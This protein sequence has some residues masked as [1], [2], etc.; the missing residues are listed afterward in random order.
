MALRFT[1]Q[2]AY[3]EEV[4][5]NNTPYRRYRIEALRSA[6][7]AGDMEA[8]RQYLAEGDDIEAIEREWDGNGRT[9]LDIAAHHGHLEVVRFLLAH[10]AN[11][12]G[13][14]DGGRPLLSALR[15]GHIDIVH[16]LL[17]H[18]ADVNATDANGSHALMELAVITGYE[19]KLDWCTLARQLITSGCDVNHANAYGTTA[20]QIAV[21]NE[22]P[23]EANL[24]LARILLEA[25]AAVDAIE[26]ELG[27]TA[28]MN[29]VSNGDIDAVRLLVE[30]GAN[31]NQ[32]ASNGDTPWN[33]ARRWGHPEIAALLEQA[34]AV[35]PADVG[36]DLHRAILWGKTEAVSNLLAHGA[37]ANA[38]DSQGRS[39]LIAAMTHWGKEE[40]VRLLLDH[41]ADLHA[42]GQDGSP[43]LMDAVQP[44]PCRSEQRAIVRL[45]IERGA[46]VSARGYAKISPLIMAA[47]EPDE[48]IVRL[49]LDAGADVNE[50]DFEGTT[51]LKNAAWMGN[52]ATAA[53]LLER[54]AN[55]N[56]RTITLPNPEYYGG[57]TA[58]ITAATSGHLE[59][60]RLLLDRGADIHAQDDA[61][62]TALMW[63]AQECPEDS[64]EAD[65][66][67]VQLL[68]ERGADINQADIY[69]RTAMDTAIASD[70][71]EIVRLLEQYGASSTRQ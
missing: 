56:A 61:G 44:G 21:R 31:V 8:L 40:I 13:L 45:L 50:A 14:Q 60:V 3:R 33:L 23:D 17:D 27:W 57:A 15:S 26:G 24:E 55:V 64:T 51:A 46:D 49:L 25:G 30:A 62:T 58:L 4:V 63:A 37:D 32:A 11:P 69:G 16:C 47:E 6:A 66:S 5:K 71:T 7:S 22:P 34:G 19:P 41:G 59:M 53:L 65:S 36:T 2:A 9:A 1:E 20:L 28:L 43:L 42:V 10:G 35:E 29:A 39:A 38:Q 54:G 18:G 52:N 70:R 12:S 68:L 67:V 48:E